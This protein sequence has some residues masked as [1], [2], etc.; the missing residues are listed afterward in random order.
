MTWY[1]LIDNNPAEWRESEI[2]I[3]RFGGIHYG[4]LAS[5]GGFY[6]KFAI[7]LDDAELIIVRLS[8]SNKVSIDVFNQY[9]YDHLRMLGYIRDV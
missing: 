8:L 3:T 1:R 2:I 9:E 4:T 6:R 5:D 7:N